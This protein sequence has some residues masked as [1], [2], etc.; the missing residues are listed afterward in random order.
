[1]ASFSLRKTVAYQASHEKSGKVAFE[2]LFKMSEQHKEM[3]YLKFRCFF[4]EAML[5][6][7]Q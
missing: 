4:V 1:M 3:L 7:Y 6:R 5:K 2:K